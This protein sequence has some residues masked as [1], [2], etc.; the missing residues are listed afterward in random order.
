VLVSL[1]KKP[2]FTI[3]CT[4]RDRLYVYDLCTVCMLS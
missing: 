4:W 1:K 3:T 2:Y